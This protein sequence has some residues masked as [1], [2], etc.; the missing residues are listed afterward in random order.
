MYRVVPPTTQSWISTAPSWQ[1]D[2]AHSQR[3]WHPS[4]FSSAPSGSNAGTVKDPLKKIGRILRKYFGQSISRRQMKQR[5]R[6][7]VF[8][9]QRAAGLTPGRSLAL[10]GCHCRT[11]GGPDQRYQVAMTDSPTAADEQ[12]NRH[13]ALHPSLHKH[14]RIP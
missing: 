3:V 7:T 12:P 6:G 5:P 2:F 11:S 8:T 10:S 1:P 14:R 13:A 9:L 4:R